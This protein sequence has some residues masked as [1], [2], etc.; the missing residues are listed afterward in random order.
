MTFTTET[1]VNDAANQHK[2][3]FPI[4]LYTHNSAKFENVEV[5]GASVSGILII[6]I[7][8]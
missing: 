4:V 5:G 3:P 6:R 7:F 2:N 1:G 8:S